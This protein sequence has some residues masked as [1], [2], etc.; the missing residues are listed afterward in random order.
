MIPPDTLA[1]PSKE[2]IIRPEI[3]GAIYNNLFNEAVNWPIPPVRYRTRVLKAILA[4][5]EESISNPDEDEISDDLM[6]IW[7]DLVVQPKPSP[8]DEAQRISY[9]KYTAPRKWTTSAESQTII[10]SESR[11]LILSSGTTGF[12]TWE[13]ALHLGTYLSTP[14]GK[15]LIQGRNVVE[16]GCGTGFLSMYCAKHLGAKTVLATDRDPALISNVQDCVSQNNLDDDGISA[17][18]WEWGG[19]LHIPKNHPLQ[20][21]ASFDIAVGADLVRSSLRVPA[22]TFSPSRAK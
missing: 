20:P 7:S 9:V 1:L 17:A 4:K 6:S 18:I 15:S 14:E 11:N 3:Q 13:A 12:R 19:P 8:L 16:L 10:T 21:S 2:S 22:T 5:I